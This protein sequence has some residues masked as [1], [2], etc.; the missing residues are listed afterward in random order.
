MSIIC[1]F[2]LS[3][4]RL[5]FP[6]NLIFLSPRERCLSLFFV[7]MPFRAQPSIRKSEI[8]RRQ[9][10]H[11]LGFKVC[12]RGDEWKGK[13][14][15]GPDSSPGLASRLPRQSSANFPNVLPLPRFRSP[16]SQV[17]HFFLHFCFSLSPPP[18]LQTSHSPPPPHILP[19]TRYV[20]P[21]SHQ[22]SSVQLFQYRQTTM[23]I[24]GND[25]NLLRN[26]S[27]GKCQFLRSSHYS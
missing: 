2:C 1:P 14:S 4:F 7:P 12:V 3:P 27:T 23:H 17:M 19:S 21:N 15:P 11:P 16:S 26:S 9:S 24:I 5:Y 10:I 6:Q 18:P 25:G 22:N 8:G 20:K 13:G